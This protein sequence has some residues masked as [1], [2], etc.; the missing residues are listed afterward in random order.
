MAAN[1]PV[2]E[3]I[4]AACKQNMQF[5]CD[6]YNDL[7]EIGISYVKVNHYRLKPVAW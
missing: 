6:T 1:N 5:Y 2:V 7:F 4:I 3:K